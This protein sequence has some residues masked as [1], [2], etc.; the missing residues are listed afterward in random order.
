MRICGTHLAY[1]AFDAASGGGFPL[2]Y[3]PNLPTSPKK[4]KLASVRTASYPFFMP[5]TKKE[6][7]IW[8]STPRALRKRKKVELTLSPEAIE[9]LELLAETYGSRSQ[10]IE[11]LLMNPHA[12]T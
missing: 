4:S 8:F 12:K 2:L 11:A 9:K 3:F 6:K 7:S 5:T 1:S 10:A